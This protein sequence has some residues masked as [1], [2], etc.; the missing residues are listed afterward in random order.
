M[1]THEAISICL[2]A[3]GFITSL[4]TLL[5]A[6]KTLRADHERRKK[7]A[8]IEYANDIRDLWQ[9][10][11]VAIESGIGRKIEA[12]SKSLTEKE[13]ET[14]KNSPEL[15]DAVRELLARLE[16]LSVGINT[17][18]FDKNLLYRMSGS[19]LIRVYAFMEPYITSVRPNSNFAYIELECMI[20]D[21]MDQKRANP[22][23][24]TVGDM[25]FS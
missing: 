20:K 1:G 5:L 9:E 16:H 11:R 23:P 15:R 12:N 4:A 3:L 18:V 21:F 6:I 10:R 8:T 22:D 13:V 2:G 7:Q 17:C 19:Y 25:N 14:I 24:R